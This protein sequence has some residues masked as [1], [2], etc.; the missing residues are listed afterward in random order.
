MKILYIFRSLAVWGGIERILVDKMNYMAECYDMDVYLLTSDQGSH[1]IPYHLSD[2]V[3]HEDLGICFYQQYRFHGLQRLMIAR[4]MNRQYFHLFADRLHKIQPDLIVC[5]T[6][7]K[8]GII[9]KVKG[10]IPLVVESHSICT[11]TL[12][13]GRSWLQRKLYRHYFLNSLSKAEY[14]VT[15][16]EG[17]AK[18]WRKYHSQ[19]AVIPN[20]IHP[21][22]EHISDCSAKKVIFVGRFDYQKR[23]QDAIRIWKKVRERHS[24]WV[25]EIYGDGEMRQEVCS[26]ASSVGGVTIHQPTSQIFQAYR[27]CSI[28]ISTSLFEP[29][30]L[31]IP[32]AMSCGLPVVAFDCPYGPGDLITDERNGYLVKEGDMDAFVGR[33][34][35]LIEN[36]KLRKAMGQTALMSSQ[37]YSAEQIMPYWL[38]L[39][40]M[41]SP[42]VVVNKNRCH[43]DE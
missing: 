39:F 7:D 8:I 3:Y 16:T 20:F 27:E 24:D 18:E 25:L 33:I 26:L 19:V 34:C 9:A 15:L 1:P 21:H 28:L 41:L 37:R 6:A 11:R 31:V 30:G 10:N 36:P 22:E 2:S 17:D 43:Y 42:S 29:F 12:N 4:K 40:S 23:V 32:E 14:V 35:G 13:H 38:Q 5:T